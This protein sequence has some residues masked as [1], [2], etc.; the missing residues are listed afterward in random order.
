MPA[1]V[2]FLLIGTAYAFLYK[3]ENAICV[4]KGNINAEGERIY[5]LLGEQYYDSTV[6]GNN[7]GEMW[8][9]D[10]EEAEYYGFRSSN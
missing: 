9:C 4:V 1:L 10:S 3:Y 7:D 6:I 2:L 5:H 8:L